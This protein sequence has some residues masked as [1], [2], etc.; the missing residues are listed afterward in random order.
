VDDLRE[1]ALADS[2]KPLLRVERIDLA[3][4]LPSLADGFAAA[5]DA[6]AVSLE[7]DFPGGDLPV[8]ADPD[9]L[10]QVINNLVANAI[11]HTPEGGRIV[12]R[13]ERSPGSVT[14][15]VSDTG[16]GIPAEALPCVFDRFYRA[17]SSRA[18]ASGGTGLGL[19]VARAWVEAMGGRIG[20]E[21]LP[22]KGSRFWF[23]LP[24]V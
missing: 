1:L 21:S 22:G 14:I 7:R 24:T 2:G 9:R 12:L 15:S 17:D 5:A 3:A 23:S 16:E 19:A 8:Q 10:R 4:L 6:Q 18:R 13:A 11:Q 20:V